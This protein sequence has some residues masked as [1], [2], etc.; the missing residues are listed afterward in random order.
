MIVKGYELLKMVDEGKIPNGTIVRVKG[1]F[2][3]T[4]YIRFE[5]NFWEYKDNKKGYVVISSNTLIHGKFEIPEK[6]NKKIENIEEYVNY[7]ENQ[8]LIKMAKKINEII[9]TVNKLNEQ[10]E[11]NEDT[12]CLKN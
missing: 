11:N 8:N 2:S 1:L 12:K 10:S 9:D 5:G 3:D 4:E 6:E 7:L